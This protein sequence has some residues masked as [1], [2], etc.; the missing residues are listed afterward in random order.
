MKFEIGKY[1]Q[2]T[3]GHQLFVAGETKNSMIWNDGLIAING[4]VDDYHIIN[5]IYRTEVNKSSEIFTIVGKEKGYAANYFEIKE[6]EFRSILGLKTN[7]LKLKKDFDVNKCYKIIYE[8]F[9]YTI[10][11][12]G[13][14][15]INNYD[16]YVYECNNL[17]FNQKNLFQKHEIDY[18][19]S[20]YDESVEI[21]K[22]EFKFINFIYKDNKERER[23]LRDIKITKLLNNASTS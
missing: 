17:R 4:I 7:K 12:I 20:I 13:K 5:D 11:I 21:S 18:V 8:K 19:T 23:L 15:N 10:H 2:H 6:S 3:T 9:E 1:Y 16:L 22:S 14:I